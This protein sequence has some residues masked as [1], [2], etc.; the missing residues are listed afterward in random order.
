MCALCRRHHMD[1]HLAGF[2]LRRG[3]HGM[4]WQTPRGHRYT[5]LHHNAD[6][7]SILELQFA[8]AIT[9]HTTPGKLRF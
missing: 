6:M 7:P 1:K 5:V 9:G 2:T 3:P 8:A 4:D